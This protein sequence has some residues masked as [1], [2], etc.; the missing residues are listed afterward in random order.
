[1]TPPPST[2]CFALFTR[3][4]LSLLLVHRALPAFPTRRSSDLLLIGRLDEAERTLAALEPASFPPALKAAHEL[5]VAG[6]AMR[7]LRTKTRSEEHTSELQSPDHLVCR[8]LLEK[9]KTKIQLHI[10]KFN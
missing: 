4:T 8:L 1:C 9:K 2:S 10:Q 6:I 5:V 7:R 3:C